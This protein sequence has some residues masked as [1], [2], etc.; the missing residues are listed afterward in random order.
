MYMKNQGNMT[1]PKDYN[2]FPVT[3]PQELE[4]YD[5]PNK[6]F[7]ISVLRKL[8]ELQG[9]TETQFNIRKTTDAQ[10]EKFNRDRN[11]KIKTHHP[12]SVSA[13]LLSRGFY[14]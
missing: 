12:T 6:E 1:L 7:K 2:N 4:N 3:D 13:N 5:L 8:S 9:N 10:N 14:S 11:Q